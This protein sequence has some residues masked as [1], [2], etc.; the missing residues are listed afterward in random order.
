M[1]KERAYLFG[2]TPVTSPGTSNANFANKD[3][4]VF[5]SPHYF[6]ICILDW[7]YNFN[8][9]DI[10]QSFLAVFCVCGMGEWP[11]V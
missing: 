4:L 1:A 8:C 11:N 2:G 10:F 6:L 7:C 5:V 9:T 3:K